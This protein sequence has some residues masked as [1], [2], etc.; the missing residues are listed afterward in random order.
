M[1]SSLQVREPPAGNHFL[2][3]ATQAEETATSQAAAAAAAAALATKTED[4]SQDD[5]ALLMETVFKVG[6]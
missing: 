5:L 1:S 3:I 2:D 4:I 6:S